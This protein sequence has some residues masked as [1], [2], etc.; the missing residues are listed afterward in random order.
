MP[1]SKA[2][3]R[4]CKGTIIETNVYTTSRISGIVVHTGDVF[5]PNVL[6][7]LR[8]IN[9]KKVYRMKNDSKGHFRFPS[10]PEGDYL[11]KAR[12]LKKGFDCVK[13]PVR[14]AGLSEEPK[15]IV[16]SPSP[17]VSITELR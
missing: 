17:V 3:A 2:D 5:V 9:G 8:S 1:S 14:L 16:L 15:T 4:T 10:I 11:L 7:E 12:W 13:L 6:L